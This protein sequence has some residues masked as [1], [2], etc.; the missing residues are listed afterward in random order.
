MPG[1]GGGSRGV[2]GRFVVGDGWRLRIF[3]LGSGGRARQETAYITG[4]P[5]LF[6][7]LWCWCAYLFG[8]FLVSFF[9][10]CGVFFSSTSV[11]VSCFRL[12]FWEAERGL[13]IIIYYFLST[14]FWLVFTRGSLGELAGLV[15]DGAEGGLYR[16]L[17]LS[18][19]R[20]CCVYVL[21]T[22]IGGG[23]LR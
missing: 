5:C 4:C 21:P 14:T 3:F 18:A 8:A 19:K 20:R 2:K 12:G 9:F 7:F 10:S 22:V 1:K 15:W 16:Y 23:G 11:S 6:C 17:R 13:R